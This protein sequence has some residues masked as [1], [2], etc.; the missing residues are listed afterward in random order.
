MASM[1]MDMASM[2]SMVCAIELLNIACIHAIHAIDAIGSLDIASLDPIHLRGAYMRAHT[3]RTKV[4]QYSEN[5]DSSLLAEQLGKNNY[6]K[7]KDVLECSKSLRPSILEP[8]SQI[9]FWHSHN[10]GISSRWTD[11]HVAATGDKLVGDGDRP[12]DDSGQHICGNTPLHLAAMRL[13]PR[14]VKILMIAGAQLYE[15]N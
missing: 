4:H 13:Q 8:A 9:R 14:T 10:G 12:R 3:L 7:A 5:G 11:P 2:A 6:V 1:G 15:K